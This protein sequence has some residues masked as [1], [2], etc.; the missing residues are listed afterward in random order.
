MSDMTDNY[1]T[2]AEELLK[3]LGIKT[4]EKKIE[5]KDITNAR[6]FSAVI[7]PNCTVGLIIK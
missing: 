2:K 1:K 6:L 7:T 3:S 5:N 4:E